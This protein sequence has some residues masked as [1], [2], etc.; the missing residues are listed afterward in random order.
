MRWI[1]KHWYRSGKSCLARLLW[2]TALTFQFSSRLRRY[3]LTQKAHKSALPVI[4]IGN[5]SVGGTGKTPVVEALYRWLRKRG[6]HPAIIS[7]GYGG[8]S[9]YP[10]LIDDRT[11]PLQCGDE[12]YM[13]YHSLE[14]ASI[15][16]DSKRSRSVDYIEKQL[17]QV[18]IIISD[19]GLQHYK[20]ARD[21]EIVVVDGQRGFG[22]GLC[23]PA[24]PLRESV[25]RLNTV[26]AI[27]VNGNRE[28]KIADNDKSYSMRLAPVCFVRL[29]DGQCLGLHEFK[30]KRVNAIA[31]IGNPR[32]FF[33]T[34][35]DLSLSVTGFP[36]ADHFHYRWEDL[37]DYD[38]KIPLIM[39]EK[40]AVKCQG[41]AKAN[42]Y[43]LKIE[44]EIESSFYQ[45]FES[46]F[47]SQQNNEK[48]F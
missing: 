33:E 30:D 35:E 18:D 2:P 23:L 34:L 32:R 22:N 29:M 41:F 21:Y 5:I 9:H 47:I 26:N 44:A 45:A 3:F 40:D 16:I 25:S 15:V 8:V 20:L 38:E 1:E 6:F 37:R 7:R 14:Q 13:L 24:G 42:W 17:S 36:F 28:F 12:P 19:D 4:V 43:Y 11:T 39:T 10:H 31:G 46:W 48:R 27:I